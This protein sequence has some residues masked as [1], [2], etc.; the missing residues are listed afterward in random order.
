MSIWKIILALLIWDVIKSFL[1]LAMDGAK[2]EPKKNL[3]K[4]SR[5]E[6]KIREMQEQENKQ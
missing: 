2:K 3:G 5:F 1:S 6:R 4:E